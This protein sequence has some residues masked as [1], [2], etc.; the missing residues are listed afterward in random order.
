MYRGFWYRSKESFLEKFHGIG[1]MVETLWPYMDW[2]G[3][4]FVHR[5]NPQTLIYLYT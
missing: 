4:L 3:G 5:A 2:N 1:V